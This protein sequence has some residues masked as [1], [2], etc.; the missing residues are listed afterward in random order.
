MNVSSM[1]RTEIVFTRGALGNRSFSVCPTHRCFWK[2]L[3]ETLDEMWES[4][5]TENSKSKRNKI[6]HRTIENASAAES[7][8][9]TLLYSA[10]SPVFVN[11]HH[12]Q[13]KGGVCGLNYYLVT[14][15]T[16]LTGSTSSRAP[17]LPPSTPGHAMSKQSRARSHHPLA[18]STS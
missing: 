11:E 15:T 16:I 14:T 12:G 2:K 4:A 7:T 9:G 5:K 13:E 3:P 18:E 8:I 6:K 1:R 17:S 10:P